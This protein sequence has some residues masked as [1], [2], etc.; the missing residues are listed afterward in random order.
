MV[1]L[2]V[3]LNKRTPKV[4]KRKSNHQT[5]R[6]QRHPAQTPLRRNRQGKKYLCPLQQLFALKKY[7]SVK[8][9]TESLLS[10]V[11]KDPD[12]QWADNDTMLK[13]VK[14]TQDQLEVALTPFARKFMCC[15]PAQMKKLYSN[16]DLVTQLHTF[17]SDL[18]P[19]IDAVQ[20]ASSTLLARLQ[21]SPAK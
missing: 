12:W 17:S 7:Q 11:T 21:A 15:E 2:A 14:S 6:C 20:T 3:A 8:A 16:G 13:D 19:R 5:P 4:A 10:S 18:D 9:S 1:A